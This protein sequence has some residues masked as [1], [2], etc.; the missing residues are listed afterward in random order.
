MDL[1]EL[2][3]PFP[4]DKISWRVGM[5]TKDKQ[6]ATALA[7]LD[8]RDVM[9]RLDDVCGVE[10]WQARYSHAGVKTVC[11]LSINV[12]GD[13][14]NPVWI[15]KANGAGDRNIEAE[16]GAL[17]DAM[18]RAAVLWGIGRYLYDMPSVWVYIDE[19]KNIKKDQ[20][21]VLQSALAKLTG[22]AAPSGA[23]SVQKQNPNNEQVRAAAY[24]AACV[25]EINE[26]S[27]ADMLR[28]W[29]AAQGD[30]MHKLANYEDHH[31]KV[32]DAYTAKMEVLR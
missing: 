9:Q 19:Y 3:K 24:A 23:R 17:S 27:N 16:K 29:M 8:A 18:K 11:E 13:I 1:N 7:Y 14:N 30:K 22:Q 32:I 6:K 25:A 15:T 26:Q 31:K 5:L 10:N 4:L 2:S 20:I 28:G 12:T 21:L